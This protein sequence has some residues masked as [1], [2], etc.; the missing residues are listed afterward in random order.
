MLDIEVVFP[1][2]GLFQEMVTNVKIHKT[3]D[4]RDL[5]NRISKMLLEEKRISQDI[6]FIITFKNVI[7]N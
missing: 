3:R 4:V 2:D 5:F 1:E 7:L 6:S